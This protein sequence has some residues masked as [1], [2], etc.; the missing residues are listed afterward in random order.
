MYCC[1][2]NKSHYNSHTKC[3]SI[4]IVI[5]AIHCETEDNQWYFKQAWWTHSIYIAAFTAFCFCLNM[6]YFSRVFAFIYVSICIQPKLTPMVTTMIAFWLWPPPLF[7][8]QVLVPSLISLSS[9]LQIYKPVA[10]SWLHRK[11]Y[12]QCNLTTEKASKYVKCKFI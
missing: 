5:D 12:T 4:A 1:V 2:I 10:V 8:V 7:S 9:S 11:T 3:T 6:V